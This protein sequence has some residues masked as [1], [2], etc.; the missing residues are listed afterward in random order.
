MNRRGTMDII[1]DIDGTIA[2]LEH[3]RKYLS[4]KP[5]DYK[6]FFAE[7]VYDK[8]IWPV[9]D[10]I[11]ALD[12]AQHNIIFASGRPDD[13]R[14]ETE[15]WL[16]AHGLQYSPLYMRKARDYRPDDII[17]EEILDKIIADGFAPIL[18]IDDR[19][20]VVKMWRRRG[21]ICLQAAE[22]DF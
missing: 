13:Y 11:S 7:M 14:D 9:I 5:K 16:S 20:R 15:A 3:R 19:T 21:L 22:G 2:D 1:C 18:V 10:L 4:C 8:P 12:A 6:N 17:K